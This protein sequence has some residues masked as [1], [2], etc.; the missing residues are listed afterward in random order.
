[1]KKN[2]HVKKIKVTKKDFTFS[3][4]LNVIFMCYSMS[5]RANSKLFLVYLNIKSVY[6]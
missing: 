4:N 2:I 1:M 3:S 5:D 6:W